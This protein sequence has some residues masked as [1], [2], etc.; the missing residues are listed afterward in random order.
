MEAKSTQAT[1]PEQP[2]GVIARSASRD[3]AIPTGGGLSGPRLL[4]FARKTVA[5]AVDL[6]ET[7]ASHRTRQV[8]GVA[9]RRHRELDR[10]FA[11]GPDDTFE[12][13]PQRRR[14]A[15]ERQFG[16]AGQ[17]LAFPGE[18]QP[19]GRRDC[20]TGPGEPPAPVPHALFRLF[21][22]V[23]IRHRQLPQ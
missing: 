9:D 3:E 2:S 4:R 22:Q 5:V 1:A 15:G 17:R 7:C 16:F 13:Q 12:A 20:P 19:R 8:S 14:I 21:Y 23:E 6:I 11:I 10:A 18:R